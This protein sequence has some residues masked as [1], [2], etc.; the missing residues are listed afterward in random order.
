MFSNKLLLGAI[1]VALAFAAALVYLPVTHGLFGTAS[2]SPGQLAIVAPFPFIVWGADEIRRW[3]VRRR[4]GATGRSRRA[5]APP[6]R[7]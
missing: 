5:P 4:S 2:L 7:A 1:A 6:G 3:V